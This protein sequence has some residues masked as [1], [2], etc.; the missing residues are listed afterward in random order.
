M[1]KP[2]AIREPEPEF[3]FELEDNGS[4]TFVREEAEPNCR[5]RSSKEGKR[6]SGARSA[7]GGALIAWGLGEGGPSIEEGR[8]FGEGVMRVG[9][10]GAA[11]PTE[12]GGLGDNAAFIGMD[13]VSPA[14]GSRAEEYEPIDASPVL[15]FLASPSVGAFL[16]DTARP[17]P[18]K[19]SL[20]APGGL[21][22]APLEEVE[23]A[24]IVGRGGSVGTLG[25]LD[26]VPSNESAN[27]FVLLVAVAS[28]FGCPGMAHASSFAEDF[29]KVRPSR[30]VAAPLLLVLGGAGEGPVG[31]GDVP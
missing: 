3:D 22:I 21:S 2:V 23:V 25:A 30:V 17:S 14:V 10:D 7:A 6:S 5:S 26:G 27:S 28:P 19:A 20:A 18:A 8:G 12:L 1:A 4:G 16:S 31:M 29:P 11:S 24:D 15:V 13:M 9:I